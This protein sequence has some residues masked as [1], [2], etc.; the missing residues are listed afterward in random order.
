MFKHKR[1]KAVFMIVVEVLCLILLGVLLTALQTNLSVNEQRSDTQGNLDEMEALVE[2]A[3][4]AAQQSTDSYD[5][6]YKAKA[7]SAAFMYKNQVVSGYT[8][9]NM[10]ELQKLLGV[11]NVLAVNRK[12]DILAQAEESTADF[13]YN[14]YNQLRHVLDT[15][16]LSDAFEVE[17]DGRSFRYYGAAVDGEVMVVIEQDPQELKEL[18]AKTSAWDSILENVN[19]GLNGFAFAISAKDYTFLD[20]PDDALIGKDSL[21]NG[22]SVEELEEDRFAW[23]TIGGQKLFCGVTEVEDVYIICA[24]TSEEILASRNTTVVIIL[25][26]YFAVITLVITYAFFLMNQEKK[27]DRKRLFGNLYYN[28]VVGA[29]I[30]AVSLVG[31]VCILLISFYMQTLFSLSRQSMSNTQRVEEVE[32]KLSQYAKERDAVKEQYNERYLNKCRIVAYIIESRPEL[33]EHAKLAEL[34]EILEIKSIHIFDETGR[35]TATDAILGDFVLSEDPKDQSY[36]FRMLL[37]GSAYH[38]Q[39]AREDDTTGEYRQYIGVTLCDREGNAKGIAEISI[40][41]EKL[42]ETVSNMQIDKVLQGVKVGKG[43]MIFAVDKEDGKFAYHPNGRLLGRNAAKYGLKKAQLSDAYIGYLTLG[44]TDYYVSSLETGDYY[45][46][47][48]VPS[49]MVQGKRLPITVASVLASVLTLLFV[50]V[51]LTVSRQNPDEEEMRKT[52]APG[53]MIEIEMPDKRIRKTSSASSRW[54]NRIVKWS[55]K[56]PEQQMFVILKMLLSVLA[57]LICAAILMRDKV[58]DDSSI[59]VY[60]LDGKWAR[61]VNIFAFTSSIMMICVVSVATMLV[62]QVLRI[63]SKVLGA[64]GET[65]C[66]LLHNL[67]KY[68]SVLLILYYCLA[69]FGIDTKT[70]LA[71]AGLLTLVIGLGAQRLVSD[72]LAGLFIIFEGEFQVGDIVTI[73]DFRGKVVEIGV[74]T[75]KIEDGSKNIKIISNSD[76]CGVVNMTREYSYAWVDVG[77]EYGESLERV[78]NILEKE[79]PNIRAHLPNIIDG[80]FYKGVISLGDNSVNIRVMVLCSEADRIQM[81][82]DLNREMKLIFDKYD[83]NIPFPQIVLNQPIEFQKATEEEQMQAQRFRAAQRVMAGNLIED[84]EEE[85]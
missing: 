3:H 18:L 78:E 30:G 43:G 55:E 26:I 46:Y 59:F 23:M 19:V 42:E 33:A 50:F 31:L 10:R 79:F 63:L 38:I 16:E 76:V 37:K 35:Q 69:L 64:K 45:V 52:G 49:D 25:F 12:G 56:T 74:R 84:D 40:L 61:G 15:R 5:E 9:A 48:A 4:I 44:D 66:R 57:V 32:K 7:E 14:R 34:S 75:T 6:I 62:Q 73:G 71:S 20:Y 22:V 60:V 29:K 24:V 54:E 8:D 85:H 28:R 70:L 27:S 58:F 82:R 47:A 41:P 81:E 17:R 67:L 36:E 65:V 80:P 83:I 72:I 13:S 21:S 77:I 1:K 2:N 51:L 53:G 11:S 39:E 68:M